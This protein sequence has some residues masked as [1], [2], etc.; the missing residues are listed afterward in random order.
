MSSNFMSVNRNKRSIAVDLKTPE[1]RAILGRLVRRADVFVHNMRVSAIERLGFGYRA[2]ADLKP[3]LVYCAATAFGQ[4]GPDRDKPA[5]DD[6][7]QA[8]C[9]LAS[10]NGL[11]HDAPHYTPTLVADKTAGMALVNA[12]LAALFHRERTGQG[13][14]VEVPMFETMVSFMLCEHI[15][16][17]GFVPSPAKAGYPRVLARG[18]KPVPTRD[19]HAV[20]LPYT[21]EHWVRF[22]T[23]GG[24]PELVQKYSV[25][26]RALRNAHIAS[27]YDE[28][29]EITR[30]RTTAEWMDLCGELDIPA[31]RLYSL[32][33]L[34]EHPQLQAVGLFQTA[35]HP[36][37][38][39]VRY[40]NPPTRFASTPARVRLLAPRLGEH[41]VEILREAHYTEEEIGSL[42]SKGIVQQGREPGTTRRS[43]GGRD[44]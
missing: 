7:I 33:E 22:L 39:T 20:I 34:L 38:G 23:A 26:D 37:E 16:G 5:F 31:T 13:Q 24:R 12:V 42:H 29:P 15:G 30:Q 19:G 9:G 40:V 18:R 17:L 27:L 3:D 25:R 41:T 8:A 10:L 11:A 14:Y 2:A 4:D 44:G 21:A 35:E 36:S 43:D 28:M 1:G 6:V 32:D